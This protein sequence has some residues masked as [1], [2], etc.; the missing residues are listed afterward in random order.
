[1]LGF[2]GAESAVSFERLQ[3][4]TPGVSARFKAS[5]TAGVHNKPA[6]FE[7]NGGKKPGLGPTTTSRLIW[8]CSPGKPSQFLWEAASGGGNLLQRAV[9]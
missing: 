9:A 4:H 8:S 1:M 5:L 3:D 2:S 7:A 6:P